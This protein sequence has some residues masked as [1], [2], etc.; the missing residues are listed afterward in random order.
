M[1]SNIREKYQAVIGL[2]VHIQLLTNSKA[3]S[4]DLNEYGA[5]PNTNDSAIT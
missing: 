4:N 3:Y 1:D 2:E 5:S